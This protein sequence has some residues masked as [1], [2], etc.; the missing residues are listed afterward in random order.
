M[1]TWLHLWREKNFALQISV[2]S[3]H[4]A[5]GQETGTGL[6]LFHNLGMAKNAYSVGMVRNVKCSVKLQVRKSKSFQHFLQ[7]LGFGVSSFST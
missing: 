6:C 2:D 3:S 7:S 5:L 1:W 4:T